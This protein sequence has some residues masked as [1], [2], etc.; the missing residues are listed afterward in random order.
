MLSEIGSN[1]WIS[2]NEL[3]LQVLEITPEKFNCKGSDYVWMSTGRGATSFIL[4]TIERRNFNVSKV[5]LLP[6]FTCNT[7]IEP[8]L[9][10]GY[11]VKT[12]HTGKDLRSKGADIVS[13]A[14]ECNAGVVLFH[15][16]FG[17][18]SIA[19]IDEAVNELRNAGIIVI[20]DCT[21]CLY[22]TF[23]LSLIHI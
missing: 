5:A 23:K 7:V 4:D 13:A 21:Q 3:S 16:Y 20:E 2:P 1:F 19:D 11:E 9:A 17:V 18:D 15:R 10:K 22:S 14:R 12:F 6:P 8:F